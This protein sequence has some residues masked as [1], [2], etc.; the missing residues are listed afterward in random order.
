MKLILKNNFV[1]E[2]KK[3]D[4]NIEKNAV[5]YDGTTLK[6]ENIEIYDM[7]NGLALPIV[8]YLMTWKKRKNIF[9]IYLITIFLIILILSIVWFFI[10]NQEKP[11]NIDN[12]S[13]IN[14]NNT[15]KPKPIVV[16]NPIKTEKLKTDT[17][18]IKENNNK[19]KIEPIKQNIDSNIKLNNN[20]ELAKVDLEILQKKYTELKTENEQLKIENEQLKTENEQ[21]KEKYKNSPKDSFIFYLW[22]Y[23]QNNCDKSQ[24]EKTKKLCVN[25]YNNYIKTIK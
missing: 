1:K 6:W 11:K 14:I 20:L 10:F 18:I 12:K 2:V 9:W 7:D 8:T 13:K 22:K 23:V 24:D 25:L 21:L 16:E 17:E 5:I 19:I 3:I 4:S 15:I